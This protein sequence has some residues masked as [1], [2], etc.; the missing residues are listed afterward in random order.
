MM[1]LRA[2][3]LSAALLLPLSAPLRAETAV[4]VPA[5]APAPALECTL[6]SGSPMVES[7]LFFGRNIG[8][9][10]GVTDKAWARFVNREITPRFP[11]GLTI[12]DA[13]GHWRDSDTGRLVK[14]PSKIL[15][16]LTAS[17]PATLA[18]IHEVADLY[19]KRFKQQAVAIVMRPACVGF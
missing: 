17:D 1:P 13:A 14:E 4:P 10:L 18:R 6:L 7:R 2:A 5:P 3:L 11:D 9:H 8:D 12:Q 15:T 19:K 16:L